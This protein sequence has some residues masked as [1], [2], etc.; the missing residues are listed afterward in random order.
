MTI[1]IPIRTIYNANGDPTGLGE[2]QSGEKIGYLHGGTGLTTLGTAGQTLVVNDSASGLEWGAGFAASDARTAISVTDAGG[3]GSLAY[4]NSTGVLTYTGP[5]ASEVRAHFSAAGDLTYNQST[6]EFSFDV[7]DVYT[8]ANFDSDF[9]TSLDDAS[10]G[11]TGLTYTSGTNT[12]SITNTGVTAAEYGSAS[13]VPV[14]TVNAQGQITAAST[15]S[16]AGVSSTSWDSS[17]GNLI[18]NTADGGSFYTKVTLDPYDTDDLTEGS[19]NLYYTDARADARIA[20]ATTDDLTEGSTNLYYTDARARSAVSVTDAGGDGSLAYNSSTG[21]LTYTGPSASEVRAHFSAGTGV[22]ISNGQVSIGQAVGTT[23]SAVFASLQTTGNIVVGG[24]L[25]VNGTTTTVNSTTLDVADKNITVASGAADAAAANGA[26]LTVDGASATITYSSTGD[27]WAFNKPIDVSGNIIVSGTVDG[28]DLATDGSKLDGIES[29]AT[30]DQSASEILTA[31]K[32]V[33]GAGS[34]LDADTLDGTQAAAFA[35]LA[36]ATFTGDVSA[37]NFNS[38][39]D[40]QLKENIETITSALDKVDSIRGVTFDW[41]D[42]GKSSMGVIAQEVE[43]IAP[44]VV[45]EIDGYKAVNYDG[46]IGLLI[47]SIKELKQEI[48]DLKQN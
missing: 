17:T 23:D 15:V 21:V 2:F 9:N 35:L 5:S 24:D 43:P 32:T 22:T 44:E 18:I 7:E 25:T 20:A 16:V 39:S 48:S 10:L 38:T 41:K 13:L 26:G 33:D 46:L 40:A 27:K 42:T 29:G 28:R 1:R 11:G 37:P 30:A 45:S 6:G 34:G 3:D 8:Q 36:G 19:T 47:E 31:I 14:I 12:L 4:N